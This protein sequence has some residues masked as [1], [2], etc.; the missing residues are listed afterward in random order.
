M[1]S[2]AACMLES[3]SAKEIKKSKHKT[4]RSVNQTAMVTWYKNIWC[5]WEEQAGFNACYPCWCHINVLFCSILVLFQGQAYSASFIIKLSI[6]SLDTIHWFSATRKRKLSLCVQQ[7]CSDLTF[8]RPHYSAPP[9][10]PGHL[11]GPTHFICTFIHV[12]SLETC[13]NVM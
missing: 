1:N 10:R 3:T 2:P 4:K 9:Q 13:W 8:L 5:N 7:H 6:Y 12:S 11:S